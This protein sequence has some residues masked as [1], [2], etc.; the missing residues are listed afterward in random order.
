[1]E[2]SGVMRL[3]PLHSVCCKAARDTQPFLVFGE[4]LDSPSAARNQGRS[5][6][7]EAE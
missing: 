1:M 5:C 4:V 3:G 7:S 6:G 2:A